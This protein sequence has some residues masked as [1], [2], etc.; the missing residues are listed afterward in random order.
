[1]DKQAQKYQ[2][3]YDFLF[4][5]ANGQQLQEVAELLNERQLAPYID[6]VFPFE[7]SN[8]ALEKVDKGHAKG[9]TMV[10]FG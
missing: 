3:F 4:V 10:T 8:Q 9:K 6:T 7:E 1:M 5:E 2:V